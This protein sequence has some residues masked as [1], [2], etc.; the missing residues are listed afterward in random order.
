MEWISYLGP[1]VVRPGF[2]DRSVRTIADAVAVC[3]VLTVLSPPVVTRFKLDFLQK[4]RCSCSDTES[5]VG[6]K[7]LVEMC[8]QIRG[9][10][11]GGHGFAPRETES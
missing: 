6:G 9:A 11:S 7:Y 2:V 10:L 5:C 3:K 1:P 4:L 8:H